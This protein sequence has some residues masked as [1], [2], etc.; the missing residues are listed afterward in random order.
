M[1]SHAEV[2]ILK[3]LFPPDGAIPTTKIDILPD[4]RK[5]IYAFLAS[6]IDTV[7]GDDFVPPPTPSAL[8]PKSIPLKFTRE[9]ITQ[10]IIELRD[11]GLKWADVGIAVG[12]TGSGAR[13]RYEQAKKKQIATGGQ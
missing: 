12:M 10:N 3:V 6:L 5:L 13:W 7:E 9:N 8:L 1:V 4:L 2:E 11:G